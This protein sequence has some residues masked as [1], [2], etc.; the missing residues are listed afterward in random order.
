MLG[1]GLGFRFGSPF[2]KILFVCPNT[3]Y[4]FGELWG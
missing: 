2:A 4:M 3:V 1:L